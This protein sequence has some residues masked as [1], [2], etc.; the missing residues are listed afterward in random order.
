MSTG[1][2]EATEAPRLLS[3]PPIGPVLSFLNVTHRPLQLYHRT[4]ILPTYLWTDLSLFSL[5]SHDHRWRSKIK[6]KNEGPTTPMVWN[7]KDVLLQM[8]CVTLSLGYCHW[9]NPEQSPGNKK[10]NL[11]NKIKLIFTFSF[12]LSLILL[13]EQCIQRLTPSLSDQRSYYEIFVP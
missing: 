12:V 3:P 11:S 4:S 10:K 1:P 6:V 8:I 2:R 5:I 9:Q 13:I 7:E